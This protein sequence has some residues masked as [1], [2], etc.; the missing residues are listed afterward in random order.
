MKMLYLLKDKAPKKV[1]RSHHTMFYVVDLMNNNKEV[2]ERKIFQTKQ[3]YKKILRHAKLKK[4]NILYR[5]IYLFTREEVKQ[6][7]VE[8]QIIKLPQDRRVLDNIFIDID[9]DDHETTKKLRGFVMYMKKLGIDLSVFKTKRGYHVYLTFENPFIT[10]NE[11]KIRFTKNKKVQEIIEAIKYILR[12]KIKLDFDIIS[13]NYS[14]FLERY[15]NPIKESKSSFIFQGKYIKLENA[16]DYINRFYL[17]SQPI[18]KTT[19]RYSNN[20]S[21][22]SR[23]ISINQLQFKVTEKSN[24]TDLLRDNYYPGFTMA[25]MGIPVETAYAIFQEKLNKKIP[26]KTFISFYNFCIQHKD[27]LKSRVNTSGYIPNKNKDRIYKRF[28]EHVK[29]LYEFFTK[30]GTNYNIRQI[31]R[32]TGIPRSSV[33]WI[34]KRHSKEDIL[35]NHKLVISAVIRKNKNKLYEWHQKRKQ[36]I[37]IKQNRQSQSHQQ[38]QQTSKE[39]CKT[40]PDTTKIHNKAKKAFKISMGGCHSGLSEFIWSMK[41]ISNTIYKIKSHLIHLHLSNK[42]NKN[43]NSKVKRHNKKLLQ[44]YKHLDKFIHVLRLSYSKEYVEFILSYMVVHNR[45]YNKIM[46]NIK[47]KSSNILNQMTMKLFYRVLSRISKREY[48]PVYVMPFSNVVRFGKN[49]FVNTLVDEK[50]KE[51]KM[52]SSILA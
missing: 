33:D 9:K 32:L 22:S 51:N 40:Q 49:T 46:S 27:D 1:H 28:T 39:N 45:Y 48:N 15:Y 12:K 29:T 23:I 4:Y 30:N 35:K 38:S 3:T 36:K 8:K 6:I 10:I 17:L 44:V 14:V 37:K 19:K 21:S 20:S 43:A 11:R 52:R 16:R 5:G 7:T 2:V 34:L 25:R 47:S 42:D 31:A 26:I 50:Y 41:L 18:R 13:A 24:I